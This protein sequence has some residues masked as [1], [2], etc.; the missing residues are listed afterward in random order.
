[1]KSIM[2]VCLGNSYRSPIA[3]GCAIKPAKE[4]S[5]NVKFLVLTPRFRREF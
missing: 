3:E 2:F 1:M 4:N 5:L